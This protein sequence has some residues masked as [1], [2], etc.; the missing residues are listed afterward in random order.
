[1]LDGTTE[2]FSA[3]LTQPYL[4]GH[5]HSTTNAGIRFISH[6]DLL[7]SARALDAAGFQMHFHALGD[8]AVRDALDAIE[9]VAPSDLRHHLAH[10]QIVQPT[11]V[12]RFAHLGAVANLQPLWAQNDPQMTDLAIP[13]LDPSLV[14]LQ[15][16]F[17]DLVRAGAPLA[18]GSDWPVSSANPL[19][20]IHVA[21]NRSTPASAAAGPLL[22]EQAVSL[23]TIWDAYTHGSARVNHRDNDTGRIAAGYAA[24]LITLDRD[25]FTLPI[26][27]IGTARVT[28]TWIDGAHVWGAS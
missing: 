15:Y 22:P 19:D 7:E 18:A 11:D 26:D 27:E 16:P 5:G 28:S 8:L 24:D 13:F 12:P 20:G 17:H 21:V 23:T 4:D 2:T 25:P 10:L 9:A 3:L 14:A 1:M 6:G